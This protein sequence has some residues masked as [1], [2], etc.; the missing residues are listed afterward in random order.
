MNNTHISRPL[1]FLDIYRGKEVK[2]NCKNKEVMI[3]ILK[4]FDIH[5]NIVLDVKGKNRFIRGDEVCDI[6]ENE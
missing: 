5:I 2:V 3:G 4:A 6:E 1:D